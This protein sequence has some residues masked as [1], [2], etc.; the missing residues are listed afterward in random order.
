[1]NTHIQ[2]KQELGKVDTLG[3]PYQRQTT[4][5]NTQVT[6]STLGNQAGNTSIKMAELGH[7]TWPSVKFVLKSPDL[8]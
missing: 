5:Q 2:S 3:E 8:S 4:A 6:G 7:L 1:M